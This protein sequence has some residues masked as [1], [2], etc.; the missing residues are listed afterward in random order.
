MFIYEFIEECNEK[1]PSIDKSKPASEEM[2]RAYEKT[3]GYPLP[4]SFRAF[5]KQFSNGIFLLDCEPIGG[6][7]KNSPCSDIRNVHDIIP[8]VPNQILAVETNELINSCR[9]ISFTMFDAGDSSNNHWVFIC[10]DN[11]KNNDYR[12][13]FISQDTKKIIKTLSNFEE[14][15]KILWEYDK[16]G[17]IN[18]P[19]FHV[20]YPTFDQ[21]V[22][23]LQE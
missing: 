7:D 5:L 18:L 23:L 3:L 8:D 21:R 11:V 10:D 19:V 12:V 22:S 9:L 15:I 20:L 16:Q 17:D 1:Y 2:V 6:V 13:G 4:Q 14:W